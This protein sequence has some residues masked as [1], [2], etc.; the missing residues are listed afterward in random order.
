MNRKTPWLTKDFAYT[1]S[2]FCDLFF[3]FQHFVN[4][5]FLDHWFS[6]GFVAMKPFGRKL[7]KPKVKVKLL[8]TKQ[9]GGPEICHKHHPLSPW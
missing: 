5:L 4:N 2:G 1:V 3:V 6:K 9:S 7:W 8:W